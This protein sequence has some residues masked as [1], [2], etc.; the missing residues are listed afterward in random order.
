VSGA[1]PNPLFS[2]IVFGRARTLTAAQ[3]L[4]TISSLAFCDA[5]QNRSANLVLS[6][7]FDAADPARRPSFV[8]VLAADG[9]VL[10]EISIPV[11]KA[12]TIACG[13][14]IPG[15]P[16]AE[17]LVFRDPADLISNPGALV[18]INAITGQERSVI[19]PHTITFM[20]RARMA[21]ADVDGDGFNDIL[22]SPEAKGS[23]DEASEPGNF[24]VF[25]A[26]PDPADAT[27]TSI[28][29]GTGLAADYRATT[30]LA[31][32]I[33]I[34]AAPLLQLPS[35][36]LPLAGPWA[37]MSAA[38]AG[39]PNM[40]RVLAVPHTPTYGAPAQVQVW[41]YNTAA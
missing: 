6:A 35:P 2:P 13:D 33:D 9:T 25:L 36:P 4:P 5:Q 23:P 10:R 3:A 18:A 28:T 15:W 20:G 37:N 22:L 39:N 24:L 19:A 40:S 11:G 12:Y 17:I 8:Y 21:V 38:A 30:G 29:F 27:L 7:G 16:G 26:H 1:A 34:A 14:V 41:V 32:G 31:D